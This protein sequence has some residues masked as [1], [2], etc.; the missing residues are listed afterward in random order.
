MCNP[1]AQGEVHLNGKRGIE[2]K[3]PMKK[4]SH[5]DAENERLFNQ[6]I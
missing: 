1:G 4:G 2:K 5:L 6:P 3:G